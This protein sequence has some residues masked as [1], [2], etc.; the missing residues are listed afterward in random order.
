MAGIFFVNFVFVLLLLNINENFHPG[1]AP[2]YRGPHRCPLISVAQRRVPRA[3]SIEC[4]I[5]SKS[6]LRSYD[7]A[8]RQPPPPHPISPQ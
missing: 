1:V 8:P 2:L 6:F 7:S 4:F 5:D 3:E